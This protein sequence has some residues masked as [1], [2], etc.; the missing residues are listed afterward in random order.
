MVSEL[1]R[2]EFVFLKGWCYLH[3]QNL[4]DS[5]WVFSLN[6]IFFGMEVHTILDSCH[7]VLGVEMKLCLCPGFP[8]TFLSSCQGPSLKRL[9][10]TWGLVMRMH[11]RRITGVPSGHHRQESLWFLTAPLI[12]S[13]NLSCLL[14]NPLNYQSHPFSFWRK[15]E[16]CILLRT[17]PY[18]ENQC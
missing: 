10:S 11:R 15:K 14:S 7:I 4:F 13:L 3:V 18:K 1:Q 8:H 9:P 6:C 17:L 16:K 12:H 5:F 2:W